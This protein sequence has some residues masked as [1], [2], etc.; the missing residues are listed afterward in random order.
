MRTSPPWLATKGRA[1]YPDRTLHL[2]DIENLAGDARPDVIAAARVKAAYL[3][4]VPL[5]DLDQVVVACSHCA[6]VD[7]AVG[8]GRPTVRYRVRSGPDGA[9]LELL[10]V[11]EHEDIADRFAHVVIGSGDGAFAP[12]AARLAALGCRVTVVTR[13]ESLSA[14]LALA[15]HE[16]LYIENVEF[17]GAAARMDYR[18]VA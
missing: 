8:W 2:V 9:D 6:Y 3:C 18:E 7:V 5:G 13:R 11:L 14:R 12:V 15:A 1:R 4:R 16:V 17:A 10:D